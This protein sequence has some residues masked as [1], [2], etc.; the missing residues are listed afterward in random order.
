MPDARSNQ[1][2]FRE[3]E[4]IE[5]LAKVLR[6]AG[7]HTVLPEVQLAPGKI[8][9][10]V[11]ESGQQVSIIETKRNSPQTR[12]RIDD[13]IRQLKAYAS[14]ATDGPFAGRTVR[15]ILAIPNSLSGEKVAHLQ[16]EGVEVWDGPRIAQMATSVGLGNEAYRFISEQYFGPATPPAFTEKLLQLPRGRG[17]WSTYQ[18]LCRDIAEYLFCPPLRSPI[19]ESSTE[20]EVN[21]RDFILPN[22]APDGL[23][24]FLR[25]KYSADYVVVD[26]KNYRDGIEKKE[27]LQIANYLSRHGTGLFALIMT[28]V[29]PQESATY[30]IRDQWIQHGKLIVTLNDREIEQMLVDK[31]FGND[32]GE[33]IRQKIEDFRLG[34]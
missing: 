25:E 6:K 7:G 20:S 3:V 12:L 18:K 32:P 33:L 29:D 5:F 24:R 15:P 14:A 34:I 19:W 8:V 21:K 10:L 1:F 23:W 30:T 28:R 17:S 22:Y 11:V 13:A 26:A 31:S 2:E 4:F 27:V 16:M 9:D